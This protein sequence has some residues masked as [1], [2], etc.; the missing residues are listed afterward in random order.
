MKYGLF[1]ACLYAPVDLFSQEPDSRERAIQSD[2]INADESDDEIREQL[3]LIRSKHVASYP[4][5]L[6]FSHESGFYYEN[7]SLQ[8]DPSNEHGGVIY[9]TIDG[10][11]PGT[12][13]YLYEE[14][15][16][17]T[18]PVSSNERCKAYVI[19]AQYFE[20]TIPCSQIVSHTYLTFSSPA[21]NYSFPV[22]SLITNPDNFYD[23]D[24]GIY[25][26]GANYVSGNNWTGNY[27]MTGVEWERPVR[28]Q[29]FT[30]SGEMAMDQVAGVR[31]HGGLQ[32]TAPQK[33]LRF[34]AREEYGENK[35]N[36]QLLPQKEKNEYKRFLLRTSFG[37]W[38]ETIIKDAL[39]ASLVRGL[40][41]EI[42]DYRPVIVF[43]NGKYWGIQTIRDYLG[44]FHFADKYD[45]E[46]ESVS[47]G[48][49][50]YDYEGTA[51]KYLEVEE[52]LDSTGLSEEE[53][54]QAMEENT[55]ISSLLN[56]HNAE[57]YLNNYDWPAGNRRW[58][59]SPGYDEGR[60]DWLFFDLDAAFNARGGV[61]Y[62]L[63]QQATVPSSA[64]PNPPHSTKLLSTLLDNSLFREEYL[65][66][67]AYLM[68]YYLQADTIIPKIRKVRDEYGLEIRD[69]LSR[70]SLGSYDLWN[71]K[72]QTALID[73]AKYRREYVNQHYISK[74]DLS[75]TSHLTLEVKHPGGG[76]VYLND[77]PV[78]L[79]NNR[80]EYFNDAG[81]R[82]FAVP[83]RGYQFSHWECSSLSSQNS[84]PK[85]KLKQLVSITLSSDTIVTAVF[86]PGGEPDRNIRINELMAKNM[87]SVRDNYDECDDWIEV[88][89]DNDEPINMGGLFLTDDPDFPYKWE[90]SKLCADSAT[91]PA[92]GF[93]L[94]FA[95][96]QGYQGLSHCNFKL[97]SSG[98]TISLVKDY[99]G[100]PLFLDS[101]TYQALAPNTSW[102]RCTE[103]S[104]DFKT[105]TIATPGAPNFTV[106][107]S[108]TGPQ[109]GR[110]KVYPNPSRGQIVVSMES[111]ESHAHLLS[112]LSM[113]GTLL[114]TIE[115][116][117]SE[118][119]IDISDL[120]PGMYI[121]G[122]PG[123][124][125]QKLV[126]Q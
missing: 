37:C 22:I 48:N 15:V 36:Y 23:Y 88:Y 71:N 104:D 95:D 124:T 94:F 75:G 101:L 24:I 63:L 67:G 3:S 111:D 41:F 13:S 93:K 11:E 32:R 99:Y 29:Y 19:R 84:A 78:P 113:S 18:V 6:V 54:M 125:F 30:T 74:F 17:I 52:F 108:Y 58:W 1:L 9:Y 33:S 28:L 20:D 76:Q 43:L 102:G 61:G 100:I 122:I 49:S 98:E 57:I 8:I 86:V 55:D 107:S 27:F 89:N 70:W 112:I 87:T 50:H 72:I 105:F 34:Y 91:V 56:Y 38:N 109:A 97:N 110:F 12:N 116:K 42:Q 82:L 81:I 14:P 69:H 51:A 39:A 62:N 120:H 64:W 119:N 96:N 5:G 46:K 2:Y 59:S 117:G 66:R 73:F 53:M 21:K 47:I 121:I 79:T 85:I 16:P 44:Q 115:F 45:V 123:E 92:K 103:Y 106:T 60:L 80:G 83:D 77:M 118:Q 114:K 26:K 68:N 35:F 31:I 10:S 7:F 25:I 90:I 65:S 40:G 4:G 126:I